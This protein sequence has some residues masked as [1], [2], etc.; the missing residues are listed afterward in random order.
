MDSKVIPLLD[1]LFDLR[2]TD[3]SEIE[4]YIDSSPSDSAREL[5]VVLNRIQAMALARIYI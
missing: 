2:E 1:A 4:R 3:F 5:A